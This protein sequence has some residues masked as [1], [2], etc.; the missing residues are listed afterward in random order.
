MGGGWEFADHFVVA[1]PL[2]TTGWPC[3]VGWRG[4]WP[5]MAMAPRCTTDPML[6][7]SAITWSTSSMNWSTGAFLLAIHGDFGWSSIHLILIWLVG[8]EL[9]LYLSLLGEPAARTALAGCSSSFFGWAA[10]TTPTTRFG[11]STLNG[12][13]FLSPSQESVGANYELVQWHLLN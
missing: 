3:L 12:H 1:Q 5:V 8:R 13:W 2:A 11:G 10:W 6:G 4:G 7:G 9:S